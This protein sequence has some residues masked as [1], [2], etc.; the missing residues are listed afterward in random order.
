MEIYRDAYTRITNLSA[1]EEMPE[2]VEEADAEE[3][4]EQP[5]ACYDYDE[6]FRRTRYELPEGILD[7][8]GAVVVFDNAMVIRYLDSVTVHDDAYNVH[9]KAG[10]TVTIK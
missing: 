7:S 5:A 8:A 9:F 3:E 1:E 4:G 10:I 6:F 2:A